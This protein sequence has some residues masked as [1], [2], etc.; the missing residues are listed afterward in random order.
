MKTWDPFSPFYIN[1][2]RWA[3]LVFQ[4]R[5]IPYIKKKKKVQCKSWM[6]MLDITSY[7]A[8]LLKVNMTQI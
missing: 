3:W 6:A 1:E 4:E 7:L 5:V 8:T 2:N